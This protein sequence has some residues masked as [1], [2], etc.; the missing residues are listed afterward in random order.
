MKMRGGEALFENLTL[1]TL[2]MATKSKILHKSNCLGMI[3]WNT[4]FRVTD[5]IIQKIY[6]VVIF[7]N[8]YPL[9]LILMT[10]TQYYNWTSSNDATSPHKVWQH[11]LKHLKTQYGHAQRNKCKCSLLS[12]SVDD[13]TEFSNIS[14]YNELDHTS[15]KWFSSKDKEET[16][17]FWRLES[18]VWSW[19]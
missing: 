18:W 19:P 1:W 13:R 6:I 14:S 4:K 3:H 17:I 7:E 10:A 8:S 12:S 2:L 15:C 5:S 9:T 16:V 11:R